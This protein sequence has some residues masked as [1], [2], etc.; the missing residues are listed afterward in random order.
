MKTASL[1]LNKGHGENECITIPKVLVFSNGLEKEKKISI[2][3]KIEISHGCHCKNITIGLNL[4]I[5]VF[6]RYA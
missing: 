1:S 3:S 5:T 4:S 2:K 6:Q